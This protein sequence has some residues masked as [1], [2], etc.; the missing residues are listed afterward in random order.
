M[1]VYRTAVEYRRRGCSG[2]PRTVK[3]TTTE[4]MDEIKEIKGLESDYA[5]AKLLDV[6]PQTI[7]SYRTGRTQMSDEMALKATRVLG[8][9]LAPVLVSLAAERAAD[10]EIKKVWQEVAKLISRHLAK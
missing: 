3:N 2:S 9:R 10:P 7:N 8:R 5:L 1:I 4:L 6:R